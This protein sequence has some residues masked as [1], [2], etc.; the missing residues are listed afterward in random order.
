MKIPDACLLSLHSVEG[1]SFGKSLFVAVHSLLSSSGE[2][3]RRFNKRAKLD[4]NVFVNRQNEVRPLYNDEQDVILAF[5]LAYLIEQ[6]RNERIKL[7]ESN[8]TEMSSDKSTSPWLFFRPYLETLCTKTSSSAV[9]D[10]TSNQYSL[11]D[12]TELLPRQWSID[13]IKRRLQGTSLYHRVLAEKN[14][15]IR[16]YKAVQSAW[17]QNNFHPNNDS[18]DN[19]LKTASFPS[20][21]SYDVMMALVTS[22]GF[23]GLGYEGV[24]VMIPLLDLLNHVRGGCEDGSTLLKEQ[25]NNSVSDDDG[26]VSYG[27]TDGGECINGDALSE[28]KAGDK[29]WRGRTADVRYERYENDHACG[30]KQDDNIS[31]PKTHFEGKGGGV[32]VTAARHL[33]PGTQLHMTYGAKGNATLLGRYGFCIEN[34]LEPD[35]ERYDCSL[36]LVL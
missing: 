10:P 8:L 18:I 7:K 15:L 1:T 16:E 29:Y 30:G 14:G 23:V 4:A 36:V 13:T 19:G 11:R 27:N 3:V 12:Y 28:G 34:N 5:F 26:V 33:S 9:N 35:G 31:E 20:L 32:M 6:L 22:R 25:K 24:D 17:I 2:H 21:E